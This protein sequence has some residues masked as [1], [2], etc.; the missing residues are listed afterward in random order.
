MPGISD[1]ARSVC[2][3]E[4]NLRSLSEM[5]RVT[6]SNIRDFR[7]AFKPKKRLG[8]GGN[9]GK[10]CGKGHKGAG[11]HNPGKT[12]PYIGFEGGQTPFYRRVP[13]HWVRAGREGEKVA[14]I[15]LARLQYLIDSKHV[16]TSRPVTMH[17]LCKTIA[18]KHQPK[19]GIKLLQTGASHFQAKIDIEVTQADQKAIV[20][21]ERNGGS[22]RTVWYDNLSFEHY[23]L[24][25]DD[26]SVK[27][28]PIGRPP[29]ELEDITLHYTCAES[30][31]YLA[32]PDEVNRLREEN[33]KL[34]PIVDQLK[35]LKLGEKISQEEVDKLRNNGVDCE[36]EGEGEDDDFL[37]P[38]AVQKY[39]PGKPV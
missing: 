3:V 15:S 18:R 4:R 12:V 36:D 14:T 20:A 23:V 28:P 11:Q 17:D 19:H 2:H 5:P 9:R 25:G 24:N 8:R 6:L 39:H 10:T 29:V 37:L 33:V 27:P 34:G 1:L 38:Q 26:A 13:K 7:A 31:G 21:I 16:D 32:H 30:R 35:C 22:I